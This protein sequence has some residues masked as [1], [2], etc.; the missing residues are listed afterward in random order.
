VLQAA[1]LPQRPLNKNHA[2]VR[3]GPQGRVQPCR[4]VD[5]VRFIHH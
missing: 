4:F 1:P 2:R 5:L 3:L